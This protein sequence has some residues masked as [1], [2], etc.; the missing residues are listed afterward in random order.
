[1]ARA[2]G[3]KSFVGVCMGG[4]SMTPCEPRDNRCRCGQGLALRQLLAVELR[5]AAGD[6]DGREA[7]AQRRRRR[8]IGEWSHQEPQVGGAGATI[9]RRQ[10]SHARQQWTEIRLHRRPP[11]RSTRPCWAHRR[12]RRRIRFCAAAP[13]R[14]RRQ[15]RR[16]SAARGRAQA[17][18]W[19]LERVGVRAAGE[20]LGANGGHRGHIRERVQ[21]G[22]RRGFGDRGLGSERRLPFDRAGHVLEIALEAG[23][24]RREPVAIGGQRATW[25]SSRR[26]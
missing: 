17:K 16:G 6:A 20:A 4:G 2:L 25:L 12:D 13:G 19:P 10:R 3:R 11:G 15:P 5:G 23:K 1:M 9:A 14:V 26:A 24:A 18:A 7:R 21:G 8:R 22:W